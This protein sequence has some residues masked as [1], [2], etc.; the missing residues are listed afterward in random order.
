[1]KK[2]YDL[3]NLLKPYENK[4]V[5][6][7]VDQSKVLGTGDTLEEAKEEAEKKGEKYVFLKTP[8]FDAYYVP[9][10]T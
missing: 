9:T 4:W 6:L 8:P 7:T 2:N 10:T 3:R 1:M 5:A